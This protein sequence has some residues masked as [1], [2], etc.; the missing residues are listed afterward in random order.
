M[1][2]FRRDYDFL[3]DIQDALQRILEYT[4]GM[5]WDTYLKDHKT[6]DAVIRNLEVIGEATKSL[7]DTLLSQHPG[8]PWRDMAGTR[9]RLMHHYFGV[10]QEIIWQIIE[11]DLPALKSQIE[12]VIHDLLA[13]DI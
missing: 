9:D 11:Q 7:S 10:N 13:G 5:N 12:Q 4:T 2:K 6:Q 1:S 3:L 8:I